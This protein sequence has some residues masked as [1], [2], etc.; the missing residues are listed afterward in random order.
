MSPRPPVIYEG[1]KDPT[2]LTT[3]YYLVIDGL[4]GKKKIPLDDLP[5]GVDNPA[6]FTY[7]IKV[8]QYDESEKNC[9]AKVVEWA[10]PLFNNAE[11]ERVMR[12]CENI[13]EMTIVNGTQLKAAKKNLHDIFL[14]AECS[15]ARQVTD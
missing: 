4:D 1:V 12:D 9:S 11:L 7:G 6:P 15:R 14:N 3:K 5:K 13:L 8:E 10:E 2:K